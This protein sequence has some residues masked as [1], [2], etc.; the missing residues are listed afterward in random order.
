MCQ[1]NCE[2]TCGPQVKFSKLT[3]IPAKYTHW[4]TWKLPLTHTNKRKQNL[5]QQLWQANWLEN[6]FC[7]K[8][9]NDFSAL[10]L[11]LCVY[12]CVFRVFSGLLS[13]EFEGRVRGCLTKPSQNLIGFVLT[14]WTANEKCFIWLFVWEPPGTREMNIFISIL[15]LPYSIKPK[16]KCLQNMQER[17]YS[18]KIIRLWKYVNGIKIALK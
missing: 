13:S 2:P 4:H 17:S 18:G 16:C 6:I 3:Q 8:V 5:S 14:Q 7:C 1:T 15:H 9:C 12:V 11:C 10:H